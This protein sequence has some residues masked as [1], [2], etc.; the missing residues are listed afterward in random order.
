MDRLVASRFR[1]SALIGL[2]LAVVLEFT[3]GVAVAS[4]TTLIMPDR[5]ALKAVDVVVWGNTSQANGTAYSLDCG[6]GGAPIAGT[7]ADQ[8]YITRTCN[9]AS[10]GTFAAKLMVGVE[11]ATAQVTVSDPVALSAFDLRATRINMAIEDGLRSLYFSQKNRAATFNTNTT[12]WSASFYTSAYS[13]MA[14]LAIQNHGHAVNGPATDI[15]Q[16]VVQRGLNFLFSVAAT[17]DMTPCSEVGAVPAL[18]P[19]VGVAS[20][21]NIG[22]IAP[23]GVDNGYVTPIFAAAIS[24]AAAAAPARTVGAGIGDAT[25]V[26]GRPYLEIAQRLANGVA[27][28]QGNGVLAFGWSYS[29]QAG[30][31]SD[32][33]TL[34]WA[35]LGLEN[36]QA[37][38][39]TIPAEVKSRLTTT[40]L[41]QLNTDGS[42][43]YSYNGVGVNGAGNMA[44]TGIGLQA[45][46]FSG[47]LIS[48]PRV[49]KA[50]GYITKNWN[51]QVDPIDGFSCTAGTPSRD[52]KGCGYAM[53]NIFKGLR[54]YGINTL[55]GIGRAAGPGPI[56]ANDWYADYVDN[57]LANQHNPTTPTGGDWSQ[58]AA[59][60]MG[61]SC[62]DSDATGITAQA[63]LI[64]SSTAFVQPANVT[65]GPLSATSPVGTTHTVTAT[66]TT[67]AAA[68][69]PGV[70]V[71]FTVLSGPNA[72]PVV[73]AETGGTTNT[74]DNLGQAKC[75]YPDPGGAGTDNIQASIGALVSNVVTNAWGGVASV[76]D[77]PTLSEWG[78]IITA[79]LLGFVTLWTLRRRRNRTG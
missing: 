79:V 15:F 5:G 63:E 56:P 58:S 62:C 12:S 3:L 4:A 22:L 65:L 27:W 44:K 76:T 57:L 2:C 16:P 41:G 30:N 72:G 40:L 38:G 20:N 14:V 46:A 36:A 8:S 77:I 35:M 70:T 13:A 60:T 47:A 42:L 50:I 49:T 69:A 78:L 54:L 6:D 23:P 48:D 75:T 71:T 33:S 61:F 67:A 37:A 55:P 64:L 74:T 25:Y 26:A 39:A 45:L 7:V 52:N 43:S 53:F 11:L 28:G 32:G 10:A 17:Q 24:A 31:I 1:T 9:Y 73:C 51:A 18:N 19:C 21:P 29:L 68:P 34:G 66:A 59:P